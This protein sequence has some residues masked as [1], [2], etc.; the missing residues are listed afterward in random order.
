MSGFARQLGRPEGLRGRLVGVELNRHNRSRVTA[1][2]EATAVRPGQAV[3]DIGFGGGVG[4][5]LLL[6]RVGTSGHVDGVEL[7]ATM[8][9]AAER[10]YRVA[11]SE[12]RM[13]LHAGTITDLPLNDG[14]LDGLITVNTIYFVEDL[15]SA[16]REIARVLRPSGRA[17]VGLADPKE[18]ASMPFTAH[19]FRL[20][21][22]DQVTQLLKQAGL[23][24]VSHERAGDG[25]GAFHLLTA[26][27]P[28]S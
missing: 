4:L 1:A 11:R 17:V 24:D 8:L 3:A 14:S 16:F 26:T 21:P 19:G 27:R 25:E 5:Q 6:D 20:R 7:S 13:A 10:R 9:A 12:G 18:M 22:V 2:V 15:D 28:Q 23:P